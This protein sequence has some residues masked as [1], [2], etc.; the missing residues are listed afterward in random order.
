M[1]PVRSLWLRLPV[2]G[3]GLLVVA[4]PTSAVVLLGIFLVMAGIRAGSLQDAAR[5]GRHARGAIDDVL[6]DVL[7]AESGVRAYLLTRDPNFLEPYN[8]SAVKMPEALAELRTLTRPF[9]AASERLDVVEELIGARFAVLERAVGYVEPGGPFVQPPRS[10]I[11][12]GNAITDLLRVDLRA[13]DREV[14]ASVL[15]AEARL[16]RVQEGAAVAGVLG[17]LLGVLGGIAAAW[18]FTRGVARRVATIER[19]ARRLI[20][21]EPLERVP[22]GNDEIARA[23]RALDEAAS[24]LAERSGQLRE[25][26]QRFRSLVQDAVGIVAELDLDT[27]FT[28]VSPSMRTILGYEQEELVGRRALELIH[29]QDAAVAKEELRASIEEPGTSHSIQVRFLHANG[30]WRWLSAAGRTLFGPDGSPTKLIFNAQD[31]TDR[32]ETQLLAARLASIVESSDDAM[33]ANDADGTITAWN[34]GAARMYGFTSEEMLGNTSERLIPPERSGRTGRDSTLAFLAASASTS[35][36]FGSLATGRASMY[37][38]RSP[39]STTPRACWSAPPASRAT[40]H[41]ELR[42]SDSWWLRSDVSA[43]S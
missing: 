1:S 33:V 6:S 20:D 43:R 23:G 2:R 37:G 26:E 36:P 25:S 10:V 18:L 30:S 35:R 11:R 12:E 29:P 22:A 39:R 9:P 28:Y 7:A 21:E 19:N 31:E 5:V 3:K 17:I 32:A 24:L 27:R 13:L 42:S 16:D 41:G 4:L 14:E 34:D 40:S 15:E 38:S 8:T